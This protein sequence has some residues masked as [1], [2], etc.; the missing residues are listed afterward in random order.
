M[1]KRQKIYGLTS[2]IPFAPSGDALI[3]ILGSSRSCQVQT[4]LIGLM[5]LAPGAK[6]PIPCHATS[7]GWREEVTKEASMELKKFHE[8]FGISQVRSAHR[9][10]PAGVLYCCGEVMQQDLTPLWC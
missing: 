1:E 6:N 10:K 3:R 9:H 7:R 8:I 5:A 2:Q 4:L